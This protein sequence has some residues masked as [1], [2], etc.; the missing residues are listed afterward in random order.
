MAAASEREARGWR[1]GGASAG[2]RAGGW[3]RSLGHVGTEVVLV[4]T[5]LVNGVGKVAK[6]NV[7]SWDIDGCYQGTLF[8]SVKGIVNILPQGHHRKIVVGTHHAVQA[9]A[10]PFERPALAVEAQVKVVAVGETDF[11]EVIAGDAVKM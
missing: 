8:D 3:R 7:E 1:G 6:E 2:D 9:F 5:V 10:T 11:V 4:C